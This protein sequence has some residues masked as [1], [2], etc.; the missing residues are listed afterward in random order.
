MVK[1]SAGVSSFVQL[2]AAWQKKK[3]SNPVEMQFETNHSEFNSHAKFQG[4]LFSEPKWYEA[5]QRQSL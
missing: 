4:N 3:N 5:L 1:I 2:T